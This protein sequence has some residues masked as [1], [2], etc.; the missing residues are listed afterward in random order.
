M[1]TSDSLFLRPTLKIPTES[2][3]NQSGSSS[4]SGS[5]SSI[6]NQEGGSGDTFELTLVAKVSPLNGT[7]TLEP[8]DA[9]DEHST[10]QSSC[11]SKKEQSDRSR[12]R[13]PRE[14]SIDDFLSR[15][16]TSIAKNKGQVVERSKNSFPSSV[17]MDQIG[18]QPVRHSAS[19]DQTGSQP[20]H[21][22]GS[23]FKRVGNRRRSLEKESSFHPV[24]IFNNGSSPDGPST[25][26]I[27]KGVRSS[28]RR[29]EK[30]KDD[31]FQL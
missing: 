22:I 17:S 25:H 7:S 12:T 30:E 16:D 6:S 27:T 13:L 9:K 11:S 19:T 21:R 3:P 24:A 23:A 5:R 2:D 29:L 14:E 18:S 28:L 20:V 10:E 15:I 31:L 4:G 8:E 26:V 1:Y